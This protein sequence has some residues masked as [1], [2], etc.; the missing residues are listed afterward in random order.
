MALRWQLASCFMICLS[1]AVYAAAQDSPPLTSLTI[2]QPL[3]FLKKDGSDTLLQPGTYR[4]EVTQEY[5][6]RLVPGA[7]ADPIIVEAVELPHDRELTAPVAGTLA[8]DESTIH[9]VL[10][11]PGNKALAA[12]GSRSGVRTRAGA[13]TST[14]LSQ[15]QVSPSTMKKMVQSV[16]T[17]GSPPSPILGSPMDG[18]TIISPMLIPFSWRDCDGS[19][20]ATSFK[21]CLAKVGIMCGA[22]GSYV[23]PS[24]AWEP[25]L[26]GTMKELRFDPGELILSLGNYQGTRLTWTVAACAPNSQLPTVNGVITESCTY[27]PQR[28]LDW[29]LPAPIL[30]DPPNGTKYAHRYPTFSW[31]YVK[32]WGGGLHL[33]GVEYWLVCVTKPN[34][35]CPAQPVVNL[36]SVVARVPV[37][38]Y[39]S[40]GPLNAIVTKEQTYRPSTAITLVDQGSL[41]WTV[42]ACN[43][44][45]GCRYQNNVRQIEYVPAQR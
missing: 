26:T 17:P 21:L 5:Q 34:I 41:H 14:Q 3:H 25:A 37:E 7:V 30:T 9:V 44:T 29:P 6:L 23:S 36:N 42:A 35:T 43:A 38:I 13:L 27:A 33:D 31:E 11:L 20:R 22:P 10:F 4:L 16:R 19:P 2:D 12:V 32:G 1:A 39:R 24:S 28:T 40:G 15:V 45:Y 8:T 18:F